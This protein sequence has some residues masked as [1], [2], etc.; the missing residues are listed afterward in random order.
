MIRL[1][2]A[3][4]QTLITLIVDGQFHRIDCQK[5]ADGEYKWW[6]NGTPCSD[7]HMLDLSD[8]ASGCATDEEMP[9]IGRKRI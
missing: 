3:K 8:R 5:V 2:R 1:F 9:S 4:P 6:D 7:E